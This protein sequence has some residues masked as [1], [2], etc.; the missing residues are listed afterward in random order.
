MPAINL[1]DDVKIADMTTFI[2]GPYCTQALADMGADVVKLEPKNGDVM[3]RVGKPS[4]DKS[5]STKRMGPTHLTINRGKRSVNWD[6]KSEFGKEATLRLIARSDIFIHNVRQKSIEKLGL[7][8]EEI[9][10]INPSIVYVHCVG[11]DSDGLYAGRPAFDDVIQCLSGMASLNSR[12]EG[13][14]QPR[15]MPTL[16]ADKVAGLYAVYATLAAL[17]KRDKSGEAV[18]VEVPMLECATHFL[19]QEHFDGSAFDPPSDDYGFKRSFDLSDQPMRTSDGWIMIAPYTDDRWLRVFDIL[20]AAHELEDE[21]LDDYKKR[22]INGTYMRERVA[23]YLSK[24]PS[25]HWINVF[26]EGSIPASKVNRLEDLLDDPHLKSVGF[27]NRRK[28]ST[29]GHYW[30]MRSPIKFGGAAKT[31]FEEAPKL[32]QHTESVLRELGME[33]QN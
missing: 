24:K 5:K 13:D 12:L 30:E 8:F 20:G 11:F 22:Y 4:K 14:D 3:R 23:S 21:R 17:R 32:G 16:V 25:E 26:K 15:F 2:F 19:L 7:T 33:P 28:H 9:K 31:E 27:F 6:P 29:E 1:L 10:K 18:F